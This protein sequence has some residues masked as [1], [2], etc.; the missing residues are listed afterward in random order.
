[1]KH[2]PRHLLSLALVLALVFGL[3]PAASALEVAPSGELPVVAPGTDVT[4]KVGVVGWP[5]IADY[6]T[7]YFTK[8]LEDRTGVKLDFVVY[9]SDATAE[10][11]MLELNSGDV[12][13]LPDIYLTLNMSATNQIFG[14]SNAPTWYDAGMIIPLNELIEKYGT[15][16]NASL[17]LAKGYGYDILPWMTSSDG[18]IYSLPAFSASLT[19]SYPNKM[20]MNTAWLNNLNL[21][22]PTTTEELYQV[23]RAF[24]DLDANGNGDPND[25]IPLAGAKNNSPS[26]GSIGYDFLISAF[27]YNDNGNTRMYVEDGTVRFAP[28][29]NEWREAMKYLRRLCDEGL[30]YTG[31]FTQDGTA[32]LQLGSNENDI[33]GVFEGLGFEGAVSADNVKRLANTVGMPALIGPEGK[34]YATFTAPGIRP[35]GVIT[36][37]CKYPEAAFRVLDE[38]MSYDGSLITRYGE[39]GVNWDYADEGTTSYYGK[40]AMLK[41]LENTWA[42]PGQNKNFFQQTPFILDPGI[43]TGIQWNGTNLLDAGYIKALSVMELDRTGERPDEYIANLVYTPE[44]IER[45]AAPRND[46]ETY[47]LRSI[48]SFSAGDWDPSDDKQ[49]GNYVAEYEKMGLSTLTEVIQTVYTRMYGAK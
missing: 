8:W 35:A 19:N 13:S 36:A 40:P 30:F 24:K 46:I 41:V 17:E 37:N 23:L 28:V 43:A 25:E 16:L 29:T 39:Q 12:R 4:L 26:I 27:I 20:W 49:W 14:A 10:K 22:M 31:S 11:V 33:L 44:E 32:L 1:M 21:G 48:A 38:M 3:A 9:P 18:N 7:N 34:H 15:N 6:E 2:L 47:I 45:I 42:V 5:F